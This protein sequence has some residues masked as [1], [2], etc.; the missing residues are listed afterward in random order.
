MDKPGILADVRGAGRETEP[1]I[2]NAHVLEELEIL[3]VDRVNLDEAV[4]RVENR[5][6]YRVVV[7]LVL[8]RELVVK[9]G[10]GHIP[11]RPEL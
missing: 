4:C 10:G 8:S 9:L 6:R 7:D 11:V 5:V 1:A 2:H 3:R